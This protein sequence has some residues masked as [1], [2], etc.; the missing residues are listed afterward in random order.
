MKN[1]IKKDTNYILGINVGTS[2]TGYAV[3]DERN[4]L[5]KPVHNKVGIG[6]RLFSVQNSKQ[7]RR[8]FRASRRNTAR[9]QYRLRYFDDFMRPE[10]N[11]IDKNFFTRKKQSGF[12]VLDENKKFKT[13]IFPTLEQEQNFYKKYPTVY[14]L[15]LALMTQDKKFDLREIYLALHAL[16]KRRGHFLLDT[17]ISS[18]A[19]EKESTS[20]ILS[21][22]NDLFE[23]SEINDFRFDLS[24]ADE[25]EDILHNLSLYKK[26]KL[27]ALKK[28]LKVSDSDKAIN[29]RNGDI[30]IQIANALVGYKVNF[31]KLLQAQAELDE[32]FALDDGEI[33]DKIAELG[34]KIDTNQMKIV[35]KLISWANSIRLA[36]ILGDAPTIAQAMVNSYN[37]HA[38][39]KELLKQYFK[40]IDDKEVE[41]ELRDYYT[42]YLNIH[43]SSLGK[44]EIRDRVKKATGQKAL[45]RQ[46]FYDAVKKVI[47]KNP[48]TESGKR[49][50]AEIELNKFMPKQRGKENSVIPYQLNA[51]ELNKIIENQG[52]YYPFL[53]T[54]N[55]SS[56]KADRK[57]SRYAL[58]KL[59]T[60]KIPYYVG[61]MK[62]HE[63]QI[64]DGIS[65]KSQFAWM[66]RK[67]DG[68]ITPWNFYNKVDIVKTADVFIKNAIGTDTY[69]FNVP[70]MPDSSLIYQRYKVLNELNK[71]KINGNPLTIS[72]KQDIYNNLFLKYKTVSVKKLKKYFKKRGK[73]VIKVEGLSDSQKFNNSLATYHDL[74]KI[75]G[76]KANDKKLYP[77]FEKIIEWSTVFED[78]NIYFTK[79]QE[80][81][82]LSDD[83]RKQLLKLRYSGW[84]KLS[85]KLLIDVKD[86]NGHNIMSTLWNTNRNLM[87]IITRPAFKKTI[88][89][90]NGRTAQEINPTELINN[91]YTSPDVK[92][93][94][95]E[96]LS[97]V[98]DIVNKYQGKA[99][100]MLALRYNRSK[101]NES[102]L[103]L[104]RQRQLIKQYSAIKDK[105]IDKDIKAELKQAA[106]KRTLSDKEL[107]YFK[108]AG[109]DAFTGERISLDDLDNTVVSHIL[110]P[111]YISDD[112]M[113]NL[114]L[115]MRDTY[116]YRSN[117]F[118]VN[119][120]ANRQ[121]SDL[122]ISSRSYWDKLHNI[123]L[124][125]KRKLF[126]LITDP[127]TVND[128]EKLCN[129]QRQLNTN[130]TVI[131]LLATIINNKYPD[132]D[133]IFVK[134]SYIADLRREFNLYKIKDLNNYYHGM[135]A[136]LSA[137][138]ANYINQ[139]YPS[140]KRL[141]VFGE[142][143]SNNQDNDENNKLDLSKL[144]HFN[145]LWQLLYGKDDDICR[146]GRNIPLF[147]RD[148]IAK[149]LKQ[150]YNFKLQN[151]S[152]ETYINGG[153][154]FKATVFPA[155]ENSTVKR[156]T[157]MPIKKG[158][159]TAIYGGYSNRS[160][161][162]MS[163]VKIT[164]TKKVEYKVYG[165]P[166]RFKNAIDNSKAPEK[167]LYQVLLDTY[168]KGKEPKNKKIEIV[169]R[170]LPVQQVIYDGSKKFM[171]NS[172]KYGYNIK[173][174]V[175]SERSMKILMDYVYD[176]Q[177]R[178]H[179]KEGQILSDPAEIGTQLKSVYQ[180]ILYIIKSTNSE[181][182]DVNRSLEK[183]IKGI[184]S[185]EDQ[186]LEDQIS[187]LKEL[188]ITFKPNS[189]V[190]KGALSKVG[191]RSLSFQKQ[192]VLSPNAKIV[193]YESPTGLTKKLKK[194][195]DL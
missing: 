78:K 160:D 130:N 17:P 183:I 159:D 45:D 21:A 181:V 161:A 175:L 50:I 141:Y 189:S 148:V 118:V 58:T 70:V 42:A 178:V 36:N 11:K 60:F 86:G 20:N 149:Q 73:D 170:K 131:K 15:Q 83:E 182:F 55:P 29:K 188:L 67:Q 40:E 146:Y 46:A 100:K 136:Y 1:S 194:L 145:F 139:M 176:P 35:E 153:A 23:S 37:Q 103:Q 48:E 8:G 173:E 75:F 117:Q 104:N 76:D 59:L 114:A 184:D 65:K 179:K 63:D 9:T 144:K 143:L 128:F 90:I 19:Q 24:K 34:T 156:S 177:F 107:L 134:N 140:L 151:I 32:S 142:Y 126:N 26:D 135:D 95:L 66:V 110:P 112:S 68:A 4:N 125:S 132:T 51:L 41:I 191:I 44:A 91:Y 122:R 137:I 69:L 106:N 2:S 113:D 77:D 193:E 38:C 39:D 82:W 31:K 81:G 174:L 87:E 49:I 158:K 127:T 89:A 102:L 108:Q 164:S 64:K 47:G 172:Y 115:V 162:Y 10:I 147:N 80:I 99:P 93:G 3:M 120:F 163:I 43:T 105:L 98:D 152:R 190:G 53:L 56:N 171:M 5:L 111:S 12:S 138:T 154:L 27:K 185:F 186:K 167:Q 6:A 92:K 133:I 74:V 155:N 101:Q 13:I 109:R 62:T 94:L 168:F 96:A 57:N 187:I 61:P 169:A 195:S 119:K 88:E 54:L 79:L 18:F 124:L 97:V 7:D 14:H 71:I 28:A 16:I 52:K 157:L 25:V 33:D 180:E 84:G 166:S 121:I 192:I 129:S 150:A 123:G 165:I 116:L 22:L 85:K 30:V 72:E